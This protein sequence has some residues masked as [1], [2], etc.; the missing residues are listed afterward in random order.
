M[1]MRPNPFAPTDKNW[2]E[3]TKCR[4][5]L[6]VSF[7][8]PLIFLMRVASVASLVHH[9]RAPCVWVVCPLHRLKY[10]QNRFSCCC[11]KVKKYWDLVHLTGLRQ[12][13]GYIK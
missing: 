11:Y 13:Q 8:L 1:I 12:T 10:L 6:A 4:N 9:R 7:L 5:Y 2:I 3:V